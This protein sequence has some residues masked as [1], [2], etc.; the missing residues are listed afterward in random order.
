MPDHIRPNQVPLAPET[1]AMPCS[2]VAPGSSP[3]SSH[4][5][6]ESDCDNQV[7]GLSNAGLALLGLHRR[8]RGAAPI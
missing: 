5:A 4:S 7:F 6:P 2:T 8:P 1:V 3:V